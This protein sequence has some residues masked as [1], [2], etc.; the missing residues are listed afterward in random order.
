MLGDRLEYLT[1]PPP[2]SSPL[3]FRRPRF[4]SCEDSGRKVGQ[5]RVLRSDCVIVSNI[6]PH[7]SGRV[8]DNY[9]DTNC[10][11]AAVN[12]AAR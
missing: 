4:R 2:T 8:R 10:T 12:A 5:G 7:R 11:A 6:V 3:R 1:V 9:I